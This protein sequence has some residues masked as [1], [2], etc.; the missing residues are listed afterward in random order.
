[1]PKRK[2]KV[3]ETAPLTDVAEIEALLRGRFPISFREPRPPLA[4][5][6]YQKI[7]DAVDGAI[8]PK[9]LSRFLSGWVNQIDYLERRRAVLSRWRSLRLCQVGGA[10]I[11]ESAASGLERR[12]GVAARVVEQG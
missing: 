3:A 2:I 4:L 8:D 6:I 12:D 5:G 11:C 1:M 9:A 10:C 7:L